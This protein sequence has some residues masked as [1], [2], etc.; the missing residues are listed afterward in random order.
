[1]KELVYRDMRGNNPRKHEVSMEEITDH[2][3]P[4][5]SR[6]RSYKY[7]IKEAYTSDNIQDIKNW[8]EAKKKIECRKN[9]HVLRVY[10]SKTRENKLVCKLL[11]DIFIVCGNTAYK[12]V[13]VNE[14]K[15]KLVK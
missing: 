3:D 10:N 7:F 8:I 11:G 15:I 4:K 13:Y 9:C 1:M 5:I 12:I 6:K 14:I 2:T